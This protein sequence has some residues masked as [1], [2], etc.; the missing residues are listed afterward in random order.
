MKPI[1]ILLC[2]LALAGCATAPATPPGTVVTDA[3]VEQSVQPGVTTRA[4]LLAQLGATTSIR[5]ASGVEVWRY[6]VPSGAAGSYGE[7][8]VVLDPRG[9]VAKTRRAPAVYPWPPKK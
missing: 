7:Y 9:V 3:R 4:M 6:L 1:A 8:V 2:A 5:F